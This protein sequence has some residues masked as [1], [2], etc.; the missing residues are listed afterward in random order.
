MVT[1]LDLIYQDA[2]RNGRNYEVEVRHKEDKVLHAFERLNLIRRSVYFV[3]NFHT[4]RRGGVRMWHSEDE[5]F[6]KVTKQMVDLSRDLLNVADRFINRNYCGKKC[7]I[8]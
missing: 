7:I 3:T 5:G 1:H 8:L 6:E 2:L 4:G